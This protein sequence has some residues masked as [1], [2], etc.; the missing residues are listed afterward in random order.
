MA[1]KYRVFFVY[2]KLGHRRDNSKARW[3]K[4]FTGK[5]HEMLHDVVA[6][7]FSKTDKKID[8][9]KAGIDTN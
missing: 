4:F 3:C 9:L 5:H 1:R 2:L 6:S 8:N 7:S